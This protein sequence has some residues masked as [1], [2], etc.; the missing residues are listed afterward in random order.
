MVWT[1]QLS[2]LFGASVYT[3]SLILAVFLSGLAIGG[4]IGARIARRTRQPALVLGGIQ[5]GLALAIAAGAW[6]IV[7]ALP[8]FQPTAVVSPGDSCGHRR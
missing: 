3:F 6:L 4:S 2:L 1:R 5:L 7:N 8:A